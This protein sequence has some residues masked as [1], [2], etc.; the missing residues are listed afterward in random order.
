M[1]CRSKYNFETIRSAANV[2]C[3]HCNGI[4]SPSEYL[5]FDNERL[6]CG[7]CGKDFIPPSKDGATMRTS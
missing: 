5:R 1:P 6:R 4:V 3:L 7:K 2:E